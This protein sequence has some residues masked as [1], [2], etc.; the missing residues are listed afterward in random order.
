MQR[1]KLCERWLFPTST[2]SVR[3]DR[4]MRL[5]SSMGCSCSN[6]PWRHSMPCSNDF[7]ISSNS[8]AFLSGPRSIIKWRGALAQYPRRLLN[9]TMSA[10]WTVDVKSQ[11]RSSFDS[12]QTFQCEANR[13]QSEFERYLISAI[14]FR[15][16]LCR[17]TL[18]SPV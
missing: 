1:R 6:P 12:R 17:R 14:E 7:S 15:L 2:T 13:R 5:E 10:T 4:D 9:E 3:S 8:P 18:T 16:W 11:L